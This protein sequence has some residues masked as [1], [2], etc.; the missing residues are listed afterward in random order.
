MCYENNLKL[1]L[2]ISI[3]K[4]NIIKITSLQDLLIKIDM[5]IRFNHT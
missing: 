2:F 3:R 4:K 1:V 5:R